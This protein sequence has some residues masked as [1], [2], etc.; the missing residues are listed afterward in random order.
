M[1]LV[2]Y[3]KKLIKKIPIVLFIKK[4]IFVFYINFFYEDHDNFLLFNESSLK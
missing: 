1:I 2:S 4:F 3:L